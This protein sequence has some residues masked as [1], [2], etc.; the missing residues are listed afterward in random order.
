MIIQG[1]TGRRFAIP[2]Q[3]A[4]GSNS[5]GQR[6][7]FDIRV[8]I[9]AQ[10]AGHSVGTCRMSNGWAVGPHAIHGVVGSWP[11]GPGYWNDWPVGPKLY[12]ASV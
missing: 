10:R 1:P 6:P 4:S 3:R 9:K 8:I 5:L 12:N 2:A 11:D 7:K